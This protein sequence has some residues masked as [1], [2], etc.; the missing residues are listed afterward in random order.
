MSTITTIAS[1]RARVPPRLNQSFLSSRQLSAEV[2]LVSLDADVTEHTKHPSAP[3]LEVLHH[4]GIL[5]LNNR[6]ACALLR[7]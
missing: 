5:P 3:C 7:G 6:V 1:K 2:F 4:L